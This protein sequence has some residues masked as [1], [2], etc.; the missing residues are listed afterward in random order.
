MLKIIHN[1]KHTFFSKGTKNMDL[2]FYAC[3]VLQTIIN[4]S[5]SKRQ[6]RG[7]FGLIHHIEFCK[8]LE[9]SLHKKG[10]KGD[11]LD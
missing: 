9:I 6:Q 2:I 7:P 8:Q 10:N 1:V 4:F 3:R 5:S 11:H